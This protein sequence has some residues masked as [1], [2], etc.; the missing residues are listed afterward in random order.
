MQ[1]GHPFDV[2]STTDSE[3]TGLSNR[4]S[5][6]GNPYAAGANSAVASQNGTK[7]YFTN[8]DPAIYPNSGSG[9]FTEPAYGG[10]GNIGRNH[11]YGPGF[12]NFDMV[13]SKRIKFTE[14]VDMQLRIEG[15]N[16]FNHPHFNNPGSDPNVLGNLLG[17]PLFGQITSTVLR[18]DSTTSARQL[19][20]GL[21]LNF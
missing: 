6:V 13:F 17:S 10:P 9:A 19:Q 3:R 18:P 8:Y 2:Y 12:V 14:R 16:I 20:A 21:K 15:Y 7:V 4:G 11:F 5:L 1:T